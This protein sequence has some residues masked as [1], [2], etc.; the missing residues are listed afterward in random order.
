MSLVSST[1]TRTAAG[2]GDF[3]KNTLR[4]GAG[5][6]T[7]G[8]SEAAIGVV[9][10]I[11]G[12]GG[13]Q[14]SRGFVQPPRGPGVALPRFGFQNGRGAPPA[15]SANGGPPGPGYHLNKSDYFL[16]DGTFVPKGTRWVKN[17]RRN[18]MN[19]RALSRAISRV[20]GAKAWQG[21]LQGITTRKY[22]SSGKRKDKC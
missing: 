22:T 20:E 12:R 19:V 15:A 3:L 1:R 18:A 9:D 6:L 4:V 5:I 21:K 17:R 8:Q 13:S 7:G 2:F 11:R 10:A 14:P 16:R